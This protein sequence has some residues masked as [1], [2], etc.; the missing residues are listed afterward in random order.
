MQRSHQLP[1]GDV[2][3]LLDLLHGGG[4]ERL[5]G[6]CSKQD[7]ELISRASREHERVTDL[8]RG[9]LSV[10]EK[11]EDGHLEGGHL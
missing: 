8:K 10:V 5:R 7:E 9:L 4:K 11:H 3:L 1:L 2:R 6:G